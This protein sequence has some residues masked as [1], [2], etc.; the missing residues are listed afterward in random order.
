MSSEMLSTTLGPKHSFNSFLLSVGFGP[1]DAILASIQV[2]KYLLLLLYFT[3]ELKSSRSA[4]PR[5]SIPP[6]KAV[7][8]KLSTSQP[9]IKT[10]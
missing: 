2:L 1:T 10:V 9:S 7:E 4:Y 8:L 6:K 3:T 5:L